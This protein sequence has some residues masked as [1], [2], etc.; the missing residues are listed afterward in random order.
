VI[1]EWQQQHQQRY[2]EDWRWQIL[3]TRG[4]S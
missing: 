2:H 4:T 3:N 1:L